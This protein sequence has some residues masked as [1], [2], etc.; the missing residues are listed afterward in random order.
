MI[1]LH[2]S[3]GNELKAAGRF[4]SFECEKSYKPE[5]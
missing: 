3:A 2:G 4:R 5:K 1:P